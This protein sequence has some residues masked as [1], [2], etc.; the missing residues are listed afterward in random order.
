MLL[1]PRALTAAVTYGVGTV[2]QAS[3]APHTSRAASRCDAARGSPGN[4][5]HRG[6]ALDAV[7]FVAPRAAHVAVVRRAGCDRRESWRHAATAALVFGFKLRATRSWQSAL[8]LGLALLHLREDRS[9][10]DDGEWSLLADVFVV[11]AGGVIAK[12]AGRPLGRIGL[13]ACAGLGFAGTGIAGRTLSVPSPCSIVGE[14]VAIA[15]VGYGVC[16]SNSC[17]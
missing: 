15:L 12:A 5:A 4:G 3:G 16:G 11:V 17:S 1:A 14:P 6:L 7:G 13:A 8:L 10:L 2:L 9:R